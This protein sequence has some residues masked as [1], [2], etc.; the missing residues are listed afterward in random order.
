[1]SLPTFLKLLGGLAALAV[2]LPPGAGAAPVE[3]VIQDDA[4][5]LH[6]DE[7]G[8]REALGQIRGLGFDRVRITAG[9][10]VIAPEPDAARRPDFDAA[11]PAAYPAG[12][13]EK[14]DRAIRLAREAGLEVLVD[15]AFWAPRWAAAGDDAAGSRQR[16]NIDPLQFAQFARAVATRYSGSYAPP[17]PP[18]ADEPDVEPADRSPLDSLLHPDEPEPEEEPPVE[19]PAGDPLPAVDMFTL[20]NEPNHRGFLL[21]Q[22]GDEEGRP[23][24]RSADIYRAMVAAAYPAVKS[25]APAAKVLVGGTASMGSSVPYRSG[26]TPLAFLRRMAC[27]DAQL[28]PITTG[29]CAD[30]APIPGQGWAH[31]PYSLH[32]APSW[33][34]RDPD[35]IPV[36]AI[37]R[38]SDT[39]RK[40]VAAG[41]LAPG[42]ADLYLTEYGYET[43]P[44]DPRAPFTPEQQPR[45]L[46]WAERIA[47]SD[48][49]VRMWPQF[50]LRDLPGEAPRAGLH[51]WADWQT[52]LF[53]QDGRPKPAAREFALP[54]FARCAV[55]RGDLWVELWG[56]HRRADGPA[57]VSV[58]VRR[59]S[60]WTAVAAAARPG[61]GASAQASVWTPEGGAARRWTRLRAGA[62][63]RLRW[64][65]GTKAL[66]SAE[67]RPGGR[68]G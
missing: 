13:W 39:L 50:L 41:R 2:A 64:S 33:R 42:L 18:A 48:P 35:K 32:R 1:M 5:L 15:I 10:S 17:P 53:F 54:V 26:V 67:T 57:S 3:T 60:A 61:R 63:Y 7:S 23:V 52:G 25:A 11:D 46:A 38:L 36:G 31:H 49:A 55:R 22:W 37:D 68:C 45:L 24:P 62:S 29:G 8:V 20:W 40:L 30:F 27:V 21:P 58:E 16:T 6:S 19:P 43:G 9:W 66:A 65:D 28:R 34:P 56:R 4:V 14:L 47:T 12:N 51:Q 59:R 44:P